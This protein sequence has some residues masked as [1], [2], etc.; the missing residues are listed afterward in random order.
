MGIRIEWGNEDRTILYYRF[1]PRWTWDDFF[2]AKRDAY[3]RIEAA[4]H[5][6]GVIMDSPPD[7]QLPPNLL[8][9]MRSALHNKHEN[10]E[11]V[12]VV[13]RQQFLRSMINVLLRISIV[14][15]RTMQMAAN[16]DEALEIVARR[17]AESGL[18]EN[19]ATP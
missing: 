9:N 2:T 8:T 1:D 10:T 14:A 18:S 19:P 17:L 3:D 12:V 13:I 7:V 5:R 6:V 4:G 15:T 11:I 16:G